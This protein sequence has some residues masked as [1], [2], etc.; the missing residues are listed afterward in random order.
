MLCDSIKYIYIFL[1]R[2]NDSKTRTLM[3]FIGNASSFQGN[4]CNE[5]F[6]LIA[7]HNKLWWQTPSSAG[8]R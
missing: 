2:E 8:T 7:T 5:I 4:Y 1:D 3:D 6:K